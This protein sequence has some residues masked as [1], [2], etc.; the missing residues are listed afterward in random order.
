VAILEET[1]D[2]VGICSAPDRHIQHVNR[3]GRKMIGV[4]QEEDLTPLMINAT[5]PEWANQMFRDEIIPTAIRDGL[6][7]GECAF[8]HRDGREIP[9]LMVVLAHKSPAGDVVRFSTISRDISESKLAEEQLRKAHAELTE[10]EAH[11]R[12]TLQELQASHEALKQTELQ[13]I[14]AAKLESVGT[15]TAGVAHE[16][17]NPLQTILMGLDYLDQNLAAG[18]DENM[19]LVLTDM[20]DAVTRANVIIRELL[21]LSAASDFTLRAEDL[22]ALLERS[23][24]LINSEIIASQITVVRELE[25][26]LP[27]VRL[28][29]GKV[30][31]VFINLFMNALHAM[32]Q[33]GTLTVTTRHLRFGDALKLA[34]PAFSQFEPGEPVVIV[35]VQDTGTG[36]PEA[37][38]PKIFDPFFTTK[39]I[40][41]GT[42]LGLSVVRK[43]LDLHRAAID[44]RNAQLGGALVTLVFKAKPKEKL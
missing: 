20:R 22:N 17:K 40:G 25:A 21:Q 7:R 29:H 5:H 39:P 37:N 1:S 33:G 14:Q 27:R 8:R 13:L 35:E 2:F 4:G 19:T 41:V 44:I 34:G 36:I 42:G 38:L 26:D 23:L 31:Q 30:E 18:N 15:L 24:W 16:V 43:I 10:S 6:W 32:S 28:D 11:L 12:K 3:A 9:V